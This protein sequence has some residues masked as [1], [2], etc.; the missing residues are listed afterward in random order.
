MLRQFMEIKEKH[1]DKLLLFR[2]GDFYETFFEDA[3]LAAKY[4]GITLTSRNKNTEN[5]VPLAGFPY[6]ALDTYLDKLIKQGI[7]VVICEQT[8]DP[9]KAQGLVKREI[10]DIITPGTIIDAELIEKSDNNFLAAVFTEE[11]KAGL[12]FLDVSTAD[13]I[14]TELNPA[15]IKNELIRM[16]PAEIIVR[17]EAAQKLLI[18]L[19][20]EMQTTVTVFDSWYFD[21]V[22]AEK[23]LK[24][25]FATITLEGFGAHDK[26]YGRTAAGIALAYLKSLKVDSIEHI[27]S[28]RYYSLANYMQLDEVTRRNLELY[29][30]LRYG[31]A[32][33]S[34]IS[35]LD[36]T[37][38]PMGK[39]LLKSW[40]LNPLINRAE[41]EARLDAVAA[42]NANITSTNDLRRIL[43]QIGDLSRIISKVGTQRINP[44]EMLALH[45][46]LLSAAQLAEQ[47][48]AFS[49][50]I[51]LSDLTS[52]IRDYSEVISLIADAIKSDPPLT[53][54]EG[55]IIKDSFNADLDELREISING[56]NWIARLEA[57]E[58]RQTGITSLKVGYNKVFGYY[59]EVTNAHKDKIPEHYICKQT[60]VNCER[61]ISPQLKQYEAKVLGAEERIKNIEYELFQEVRL[62]LKKYLELMQEFVEVVA[63]IDVLASF[64]WLA[65]YNNYC[66]PVFN[67]EGRLDIR[68][69]R[70]PVIE[71]LLQQEQFIPNDVEMNNTDNRIILLTGPNMAG[72]STY[73]RQIGLLAIMAQS[74][75]FVPAASADLP[76]F[77][78]VFTRVGASDN[79][80]QGQSTFLV[81]MLETANIINS[82]TPDSLIL[83]DEIGRGTS[84]FDGLSLAWAIVEHLHNQPRLK[85]KTLFATHYHE[86]TELENLLPAVK[87]YNIAVKE[88][89]DQII[90]LRKIVRGSAD[91]SYGIHVA[92]LAGMPRSV[93]NRA[94]EILRNLEEHELSP[95]GL[96]GQSRKKKK[97]EQSSQL[98]I[99][100]AMLQVD[101]E[102]NVILAE[103]KKLDV[104]NLTPMEAINKLAELKSKL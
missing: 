73:L 79:L 69:C 1:P 3:A 46:Y 58:R 101:T 87:N 70:H 83:L 20:S 96:T 91:Q 11:D 34:L 59:L 95:Q 39:R 7:K 50:N 52:H 14:F 2:M 72:K 33:G 88:W 43:D 6:H 22:E 37:Q 8:E 45:N 104:N 40:I 55:N 78:K 12:A 74:G 89:N 47:L 71:K 54:T 49:E 35:V 48:T 85:A 99:F 23:L 77:D 67:E 63:H 93:L 13:F 84:T 42:F 100:D 76:I 57:E 94:N 29:R 28:L 32:L 10:I 27:T 97:K 53:I 66:K 5:A 15:E 4:L 103:I 60:L 9:K 16:Q 18:S 51:L 75:C 68:E 19:L 31:T 82:A 56:K 64:S 30:S 61:Y 36:Q 92:R 41:I 80:A 62:K 65:Y 26:L 90:F 21:P 24:D 25:H 38:T 44:R 81:E 86:L 98:D 102:K 17:D